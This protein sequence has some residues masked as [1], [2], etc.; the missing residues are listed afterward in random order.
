MTFAS[1]LVNPVTVQ[2]Y[3]SVAKDDYGNPIKIWVDHLDIMGRLSYP[4]GRQLQTATETI[5]IEAVLF[6]EDEDVTEYDRVSI[7]CVSY[8]ILFVADIQDSLGG[9]HRELLLK[10]IKP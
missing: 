5:P 8:E 9:H 1:L 7:D 2:R 6:I 4:K 10:R 3:T